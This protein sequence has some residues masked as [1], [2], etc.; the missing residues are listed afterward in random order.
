MACDALLPSVDQLEYVLT[1]VGVLCVGKAALRGIW[2][3]V[4]GV[5]AHFCSRLW[6][7]RLVDVYGKWAVV[8]GSTDGIG[9]AYA[10]ELAKRGV[11]IVLIS[12][13]LDKLK[14]VAREIV[15]DYG[16]E[17]DVIQV[18]FCDGLPIYDVIKKHLAN[19]DIGILV[20]NV[21]MSLTCPMKFNQ[22]TESS[23][24]GHVNVNMASV[25][26]MTHLLLPGMLTKGRGAVVNIASIT[27]I[28]PAPLLGIYAASKSFVDSFSQGLEWECRGSGVTIQTL[29]PGL[30]TTN[31]TKF[32]SL[33]HKTNVFSPSPATF[34]YHAVNTLG[35]ARRTTGYW[36]HGIQLFVLEN[37]FNQWFYM[38]GCSLLMHYV[39]KNKKNK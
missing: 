27:A 11:N 5:R 24:W 34:A 4:I 16:V 25:P 20:N 38:H 35:Y 39:A 1:V 6:D 31:M 23:I 30:V 8:T 13:N 10:R 18:N 29:T 36:A 7:K 37:F 26:A 14:N 17:T 22:V 12:R 21:G 32:S 19:K 2:V 3:I 15:E 9:K 33:L 28:Y